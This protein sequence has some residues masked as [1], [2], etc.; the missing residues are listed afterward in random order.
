[1][2]V[3]PTISRPELRRGNAGWDYFRAVGRSS[4]GIS[5]RISPNSNGTYRSRPPIQPR[6]GDWLRSGTLAHVGAYSSRA[7]D[8]TRAIDRCHDAPPNRRALG[9][10]L[11]RRKM[12]APSSRKR[13]TGHDVAGPALYY[14][15]FI[16]ASFPFL[17][18]SSF[19]PQSTSQTCRRAASGVSAARTSV[20]SYGILSRWL[21]G[22][23]GP[24]RRRPCRDT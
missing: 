16:P 5:G 18:S 3:S 17:Q 21:G 10:V 11:L 2:Q 19:V 23:R 8:N 9:S 6:K 13:R 20:S 12:K 7:P 22:R 14:F 1:M 15:S 24:T 4:S